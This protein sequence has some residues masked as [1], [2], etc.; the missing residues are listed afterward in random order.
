[1]VS[2]VLR[3]SLETLVPR[4]MVVLLELL[5]LLVHLDLRYRQHAK[6]ITYT[7]E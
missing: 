1:M 4:V 3:E 5:E 6:H 7:N 2:L